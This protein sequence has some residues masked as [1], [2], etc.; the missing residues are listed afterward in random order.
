MA[1]EPALQQCSNPSQA[2]WWIGL[3]TTEMVVKG[4]ESLW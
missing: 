2:L 1:H 3:Q 4:R